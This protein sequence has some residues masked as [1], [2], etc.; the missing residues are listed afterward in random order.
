MKFAAE[1]RAFTFDLSQLVNMRISD[2]WGEVQARAQYAHSEN[3]YLIHYKA[4]DGCARTDWFAESVLDAV[5]DE[6]HPG[7]P[8][9]AATELPEGAT[10]EA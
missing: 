7:C 10:V 4:T 1:P 6:K 2:E 8:V 5:A 9:Y 3:Q